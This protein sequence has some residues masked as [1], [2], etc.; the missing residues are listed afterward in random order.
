[1]KS[2]EV[3]A[4]VSFTKNLG[5]F[6]SLRIEAGITMEIE[7]GEDVEEVFTQTFKLAKQEVRKQLNTR[8]G[9]RNHGEIEL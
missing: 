9:E 6:Q 4:A 1:M 5:N 3:H 8:K 2:K 7:P